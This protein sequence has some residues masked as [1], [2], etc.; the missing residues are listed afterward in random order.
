MKSW[1][2]AV[3]C[4]AGLAMAG[5]RAG[6]PGVALLEQENRQLEARLYELAGLMEESRQ[7]NERLRRRLNRYE[8]DGALPGPGAKDDAAEP[9]LEP[10]PPAPDLELPDGLQSPKVE[11]PS[12]AM[13]GGE[14]LETLSGGSAAASDARLPAP[15]DEEALDGSM[16]PDA[17]VG[18]P[19]G[20]APEDAVACEADNTQ[21]AAITLNERL[22]GGYDVDRRAGHEGIITV[23]EPRDGDGRLVPAAAPVSVVVLDPAQPGDAARVARWDLTAEEIAQRYRKT[24]LSEGIHLELVWPQALPIHRRLHLFVRYV[25]DDGRKLQGDREIEIDVPTLEA[26]RP[27]PAASAQSSREPAPPAAEWQ[28]RETPASKAP[29]AQP[30]TDQPTRTAMVPSATGASSAPTEEPRSWSESPISE[31][32]TP[33][34]SARRRP[35]WSPDRP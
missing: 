23:V 12:A 21:V 33:A 22:T 10:A 7:E 26:Q 19:E 28:P 16:I 14:F 17:S 30:P 11:M 29:A 27:A 3:F 25:T 32:S 9:L 6:P 35:A 1:P 31:S 20:D 34:S 4:V 24:P 8:R 13:P 15:P 18:E 5:C 2:F